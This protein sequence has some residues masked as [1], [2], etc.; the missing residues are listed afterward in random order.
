MRITALWGWY[1]RSSNCRHNERGLSLTPIQKRG[2]GGK[3]KEKEKKKKKK[4][5][6][7]KEK[8]KTCDLSVL[9]CCP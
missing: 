1:N 9:L 8:K 2:E 4:K 7:K 6:K 3:E 5:K